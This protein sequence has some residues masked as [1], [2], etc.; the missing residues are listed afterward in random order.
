[1]AVQTITYADKTALNLNPDVDAVNKCQATDLNEIKSVVNNNANEL[2]DVIVSGTGTNGSYIKFTD[3]TMI[4]YGTM[5]IP[6]GTWTASGSGYFVDKTGLGLQFPEAFVS[7][8]SVTATCT[9]DGIYCIVASLIVS[10]TAITGGSFARF[11]QANSSY[12]MIIYYQA[13]GKWK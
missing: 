11:T 5:T 2:S 4:C 6:G 8:P 9:N 10:A 7:V 13:I 1:M 3:G 12:S